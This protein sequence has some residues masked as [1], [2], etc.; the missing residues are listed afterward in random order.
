MID[1]NLPPVNTSDLFT[2]EQMRKFLT[3]GFVIIK[4]DLPKSIHVPF[5]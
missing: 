1:T 3:N 5:F 2:D 4:P